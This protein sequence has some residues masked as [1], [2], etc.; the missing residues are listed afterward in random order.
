MISAKLTLPT[1]TNEPI[2]DYASK[3]PERAALEAEIARQWDAPLE[4]PAR[5]NVMTAAPV[6]HSATTS[7]TASRPF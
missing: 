4:V 1:P 5:P 3:S 6:A 2:F 7:A